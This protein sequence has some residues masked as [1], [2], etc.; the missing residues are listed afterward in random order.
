MDG[1]QAF[2]GFDVHAGIVY[3]LRVHDDGT[4]V[5]IASAPGPGPVWSEPVVLTPVPVSR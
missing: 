5:L 2:G 3:V 1:V 4:R